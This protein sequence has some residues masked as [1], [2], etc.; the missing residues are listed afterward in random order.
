[1]YACVDSE[2]ESQRAGVK[3][4]IR[5]LTN[6]V[7]CRYLSDILNPGQPEAYI[8]VFQGPAVLAAVDARFKSTFGR[9][10]M[11]PISQ[12]LVHYGNIFLKLSAPP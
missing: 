5:T 4:E 2:S 11:Q 1:M 3:R 10:S 6:V 9:K 12:R 7:G 8:W